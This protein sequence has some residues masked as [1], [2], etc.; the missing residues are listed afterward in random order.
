MDSQSSLNAPSI[1]PPTPAITI[2]GYEGTLPRYQGIQPLFGAAR[3]VS[4]S[5]I[6]W[7][8]ANFTVDSGLE[9]PYHYDDEFVMGW[10][11]WYDYDPLDWNCW[12]YADIEREYDV[13]FK[14]GCM[15]GIYQDG[16]DPPHILR[17]NETKVD[18]N[19]VPIDGYWE[20]CVINRDQVE[21][22]FYLM[23][24]NEENLDVHWMQ[25]HTDVHKEVMNWVRENPDAAERWLTASPTP[26]ELVGEDERLDRLITEIKRAIRQGRID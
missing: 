2:P 23:T 26:Q 10:D 21:F 16:N 13:Q 19:D 20:L 5:G 22:W 14:W 3:F 24:D 11:D 4:E 12:M 7:G 18:E 1:T 9:T 8:Y 25:S 15:C 17:S 6:C